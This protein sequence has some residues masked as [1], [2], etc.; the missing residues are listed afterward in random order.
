MPSRRATLVRV[1]KGRPWPNGL[2]RELIPLLTSRAAT[3]PTTLPDLPLSFST[4]PASC[5]SQ[6]ATVGTISLCTGA[7][8]ASTCPPSGIQDSEPF[9][10]SLR[11]PQRDRG[12][13]REKE[14][15]GTIPARQNRTKYPRSYRSGVIVGQK[16]RYTTRMA[17]NNENRPPGRGAKCDK[18]PQPGRCRGAT[19]AYGPRSGPNRAPR[20]GPNR[21]PGGGIQAHQDRK[22]QC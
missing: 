22:V 11:R 10:S 5:S 8:G 18:P 19:D 17:H 15:G 7:P 2:T 13:K 21:A 16:R 6:S 12:P 20:S 14:S 3:D 4:E 1:D 9:S